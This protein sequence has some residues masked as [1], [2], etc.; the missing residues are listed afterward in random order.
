MTEYEHPTK[1]ARAT[2]LQTDTWSKKLQGSIS[3][4]AIA[5]MEVAAEVEVKQM[6]ETLVAI[7]LDTEKN[8]ADRAQ[9]LSGTDVER[10][11]YALI[12]CDTCLT[13]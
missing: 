11:V 12:Y 3:F 5:H 10:T 7:R 8:V 1:P 2:P 4:V 6:Q 13:L 9:P